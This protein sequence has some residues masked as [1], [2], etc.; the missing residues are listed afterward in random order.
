MVLIAI[1]AVMRNIIGAAGAPAFGK[2][3]LLGVMNV[4]KSFVL[5]VGI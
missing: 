3:V 2:K 4:T 1:A 5:K